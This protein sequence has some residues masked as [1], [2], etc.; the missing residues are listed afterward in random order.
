MEWPIYD[1]ILECRALKF[2][3]FPP[4]ILDLRVKFQ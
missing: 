3:Y 4:F 1:H 2:D